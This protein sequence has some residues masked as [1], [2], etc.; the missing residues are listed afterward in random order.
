[1]SASIYNGA[2]TS[3]SRRAGVASLEIDGEVMDVASD[4]AY[5]ATRVKREE[6]DGQSGPQGYSENLKYGFISATLR[7][8][9]TLSQQRMMEKVNVPV[10]GVTAT[11]KTVYGDS[12]TCMECSEVKT[13]EGTFEVKFVGYVTESSY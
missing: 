12:L 8:S 5:D 1:M 3:M 11:G 6:F 4:L 7:D 9:G 13:A 2:T 10:V